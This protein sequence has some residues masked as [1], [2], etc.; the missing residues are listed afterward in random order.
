MT[1]FVNVQDTNE[2]PRF[3]E[4]DYNVTV[5]AKVPAHQALLQVKATDVDS[6]Q[7]GKISYQ[8]QSDPTKQFFI[9][10]ESGEIFVNSEVSFDFLFARI[11]T[12]L[13][14]LFALQPI[15]WPKCLFDYR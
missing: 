4:R 11:I 10:S 7:N 9:D 15:K 3:E 14:R 6:D 12:F 2:A 1:I 13:G 5:N 8:I